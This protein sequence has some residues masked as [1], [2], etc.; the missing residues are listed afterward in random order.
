[1][2]ELKHIFFD[3]DH[4]LWDFEANSREALT[5]LYQSLKLSEKGLPD[6][7]TFI[8]AYT[9][10][11]AKC[12]EAYRKGEMSKESLRSERFARAFRRFGTD[13]FRTAEAAGRLYIEI[14]P[15]K[16]QLI[17]GTLNL[18][19]YMASKNYRMHI[20]TNG[21]EEVQHIKVKQSGIEP[22]FENLITSEDLGVK[23]PHPQ[24]FLGALKR[25]G[26]QA[27]ASAMIGDNLEVDVV[28]ARE[29]GMLAAYFNPTAKPH[30][31]RVAIETRQLIELRKYF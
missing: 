10:E 2:P 15:L 12:W 1:M 21:F 28:G 19:S 8:K 20:L 5:E 11:N 23:K 30:T 17:P 4:T 3:L 22:Y 6:I 29:V 13:D 31:E 9:E 14:S 24:A 26:S 18:L 7:N 27:A 25:T 16:T